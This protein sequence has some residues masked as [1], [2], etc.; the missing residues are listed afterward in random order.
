MTLQ[1][2]QAPLL[3]SVKPWL[4]CMV[5]RQPSLKQSVPKVL[6]LKLPWLQGNLVEK[7]RQLALANEGHATAD[8]RATAAQVLP[9]H[10]GAVLGVSPSVA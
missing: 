7:E 2:W 10:R 5:C 1:P 3:P 9:C 8:A 4:A 6:T